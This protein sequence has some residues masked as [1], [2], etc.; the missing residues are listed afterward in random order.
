MQLIIILRINRLIFVDLV[1]MA[2]VNVVPNPNHSRCPISAYEFPSANSLFWLLICRRFLLPS[3]RT[4]VNKVRSPFALSSSY[5][6]SQ[7]SRR[8]SH[9]FQVISKSL[10]TIRQEIYVLYCSASRASFMTGRGVIGSHQATA[11]LALQASASRIYLSLSQWYQRFLHPCL[12]IGMTGTFPV[13]SLGL[14][15]VG[16]WLFADIG[17]QATAA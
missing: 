9:R 16:H 10:I 1:W 7:Y 11:F 14:Q 5:D 17:N 12:T 15:T 8:K 3:C 2:I 6:D 13:H 4:S